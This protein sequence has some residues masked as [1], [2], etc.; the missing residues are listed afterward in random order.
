M[1]HSHIVH[2]HAGQ[3]YLHALSPRIHR[4]FDGGLRGSVA[5]A[6][7]A[8][9]VDLAPSPLSGGTDINECA[10][11]GVAWCSASATCHNFPGSYACSPFILPESL[12][13]L[14]AQA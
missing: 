8:T 1:R 2:K 11:G 9:N 3:P 12:V 5:R 10:S 6:E 14:D 7:C 13:P 4:R